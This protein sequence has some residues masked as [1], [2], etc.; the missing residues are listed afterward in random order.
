MSLATGNPTNLRAALGA[1][2]Q[3]RRSDR[4]RSTRALEGLREGSRNRTVLGVLNPDSVLGS[5]AGSNHSERWP[6]KPGPLDYTNT[7]W[8]RVPKAEPVL[9][10]T[11][12]SA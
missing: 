8:S 6:Y 11:S 7:M 1:M 2:A 10:I 9:G 5:E 12:D 3:T 4:V